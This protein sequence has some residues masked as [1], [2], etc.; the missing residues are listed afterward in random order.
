MKKCIL[1]FILFLIFIPSVNAAY[2]DLNYEVTN[3]TLSN[4]SLKISGYAFIHRTNNYVTVYERKESDTNNVNKNNVVKSDGGQ[5]VKIK[6]VDSNNTSNYLEKEYLCVDDNYNFYYQMFYKD[7]SKNYGIYDVSTYNDVSLNKCNENGSQCYYEDLGFEIKFSVDELLEKFSSDSNLRLYIAAYNK[8]FGKYTDY[9][10]LKI[11]N[12]SGSSDYIEVVDGAKRNGNVQF[13]ASSALLWNINGYPISGIDI[14]GCSNGEV[15]QGICSNYHYNI[16][17]LN[18]SNCSGVNCFKNG[19]KIVKNDGLGGK[20]FL[21]NTHSPGMYA[22]CVTDSGNGHY[23]NSCS[24]DSDGY[25]N[26]CSGN[27]YLAFGSWVTLTGS[28]QLVIK[29]KDIKKCDLVT[30]SKQTLQCNDNKILDSTCEELTV[31]TD[32]GTTDVKIEQKGY[33]SSVLT[34]DI[35]YAGAAFNFGVM[36][37][38]TIK[39]S[40]VK[41]VTDTELKNAVI[42]EMKDKI[43]S[44]DTYIAGLNIT[45]LKLGDITV[46]DGF[47]VKKCTASSE[48]KDYLNTELTV[49]C[50]FYF[51]KSSISDDGEVTYSAGIDENG[52]ENK[53]YTPINYFK[54]KVIL[55]DQVYYNYPITLNIEGMSRITDNATKTDSSKKGTAWTGSWNDT[56]NNCNI[57]LYPLLYNGSGEGNNVA[58]F[59]FIYRPIDISNPFPNRNAGINWYEWWSND[60]N[61]ELLKSSYDRLQYVAKL[62]NVSIAKI[63]N[64]N[65]NTKNGYFDWDTMNGEKSTFIDNYD[66]ISRCN[67]AGV[68]S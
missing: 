27:K 24:A 61:K 33:I 15:S 28:S 12:V 2:G 57:K 10:E 36:Y 17:N 64:Y 49:S 18:D 19:F 25:C 53:Y 7:S 59:N 5:K 68:C 41:N 20:S 13:I 45:N 3:F 40:F 23:L 42:E 35:T 52:I 8:D 66:Y 31:I 9:K 4:D 47:L 29:V 38:N 22:L 62:N 46:G 1:I 39:W 44:F 32:K 11:P 43:K 65:K 48:N 54:N 14:Y 16:L 58:L 6:I 50:V 60:R 51:P 30:P 56:F 21:N 37:T 67:E 55:G 63:K 26:S 34:P